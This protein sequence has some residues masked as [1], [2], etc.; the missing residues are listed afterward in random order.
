MKKQLFTLSILLTGWS[1]FAQDTQRA[2][3]TI[4]IDDIDLDEVVIVGSRAGGRTKTESPVPVDVFDL[5]KTGK[6]LPQ[7]NINQILNAIAPSFTSTVQTVAD[8]TDHLD[9]A[10]LRGLGPDQT[11]VLINGKRRHIS[12]FINVN[13]TPGRGTVGTD[14]NAIPSFALSK[15][16]VLRD[17]A[18][19]QYGSDAIAGVINFELKK[20][21]GLSAQL[22]Y[23]G[24]LTPKANDHRGD[25]DG[26]QGQFDLNYGTD[27][28][29]KGGF[30]NLTFSAQ[31]REPTRRAGTF[32]GTVF[33]AYNAIEARALADGVNLSS[34]FTNIN[35]I[36]NPNAFVGLVQNYAG[37]VNYFDAA[38]LAQIQSATSINEL[39]G[40]LNQ[41]YTEQELAY[42]GLSRKDYNMR[43]GQSRLLGSQLFFNTIIPIDD[44]WR[45][46]GFGGY[47]YRQGNAAGFFR[48]PNQSRTYTGLYPDGFLPEI[49]TAIQDISV[50]SGI[51]GRLGEWS[52]DLSNTFGRNSFA[53]TIE[54]TSNTSLQLNSPTSFDAGKLKFVQNT[55]NLDF[56]RPVNLFD[57]ADFS[58]GLE[59]RHEIFGISAGEEASYATYDI[60][61]NLQT[62][63]TPNADKPTDF[64]GNTLPGG[65]QVFSGFRGESA[66]EKVRNVYAAYAEFETDFNPW[67][68]AN[69]ALR[70]ENYSDFGSTFNYK[71]AS[72][73]KLTQNLN[74]RAA[75]STGFRAPSIH[76]IYYSNIGTLFFNGQLVETGTFSN[77]SEIASLF[78]IEK[79]REEKSKSV[80]A[81]ITYTLPN[82]GLS[83]TADAYFIR[84]DDRIVLTETFSRPTNPS[85][86]EQQQLQQLFDAA[87]VTAAQFF[88]NAIDAETKG[89]DVVITHNLRQPKW[90]LVND[91]GINLTQTRKV[92]DVHVPP[93]VAANGLEERF[94]SERI[95]VYL[96]EAVPRT[97]ASLSHNL[98]VGKWNAYL[99]NTFYGKTTG[100]DIVSAANQLAG[101]DFDDRGHQIIKANVI[102]DL[103]GSY[104]FNKHLTLTLG[105]NNLFDVYPSRNV[106]ASSNNDQFVYSR[107]TSQ[108][109]LNGRFLFARLNYQL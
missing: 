96:E 95:R 76:Q 89:I 20:D 61:G 86:P 32:D 10:Q 28:G 13:G 1:V 66:T 68:L 5:K 98:T 65:A 52:V 97:K 4:Y 84:V 102:T 46:Y 47:G 63:L 53:Y 51:K 34:Y 72:R 91:F 18:S 23:G 15:I 12:A 64:F 42:R 6:T 69:V 45:V 88:A 56:S 103:S 62:P 30:V 38:Y 107:A 44:T 73:A 71:I 29:K 9:P 14:L 49:E 27:I 2:N 57:R 87:N 55:V 35:G 39:Q 109:G 11:L 19:A 50:S 26:Q 7:A 85:T 104:N 54:N 101:Y 81:G 25:Y 21:R 43:V 33:N 22:S 67:L 24:H 93:I 40:L 17:G 106:P 70:Y 79:L 59:Q 99:R 90:N 8:G 31:F 92:G 82:S 105:V 37:N 74:L 80:S 41:D 100:P 75:A 60:F 16:E 48:R 3:D 36:S 78:G 108:F 77:N 58:F 83:L 94:F